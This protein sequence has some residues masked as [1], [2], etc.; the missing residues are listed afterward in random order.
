MNSKI[1]RI[2]NILQ[3]EISYILANEIKDNNI[4]NLSVTA[5][6]TSSDLSYAK[7]Y[8]FLLDEEYKQITLLSLKK[9]KGFIK[10]SLAER[11]ELR[12]I[13]ELEFVY[14]ESIDYGQ[15]IENILNKI[16]RS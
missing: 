16:N 13:P 12:H 2:N 3:K 10:K 4:K 1:P 6:K 14:D 15:N 7:V 11:V 9:A 5:V 8:I